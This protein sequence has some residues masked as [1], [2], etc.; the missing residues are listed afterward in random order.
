MVIISPYRLR[1]WLRLN[2]DERLYY[3]MQGSVDQLNLQL[4]VFKSTVYFVVSCASGDLLTP[5]FLKIPQLKNGTEKVQKE[6][7]AHSFKKRKYLLV[8]LLFCALYRL[9]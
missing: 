7:Q 6:A 5:H 2:D 4:S 3:P 9:Q 1:H 8:F